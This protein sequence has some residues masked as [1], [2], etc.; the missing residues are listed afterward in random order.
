MKVAFWVVCVLASVVGMSASCGPERAFC[1][2]RHDLNCVSETDA[3]PVGGQGGG[4]ACGPGYIFAP[5]DGGFGCIPDP[6]A[7]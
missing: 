3:A 4:S 5:I 1:P 7:T 2:D 6:N